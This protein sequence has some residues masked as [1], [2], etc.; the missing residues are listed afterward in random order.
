[1]RSFAT[2]TNRSQSA[3]VQDLKSQGVIKAPLVI[4]A[5]TSIDRV[6]YCIPEAEPYVDAAMA[7]LN[8][9]TISA[10]HMH[11]H[12]LELLHSQIEVSPGFVLS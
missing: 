2:A 3:L 6:H 10:P 4:S 9:Q 8:G 12:A 5:M 1:M 7:T 11:G